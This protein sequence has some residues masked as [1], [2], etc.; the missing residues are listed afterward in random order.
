MKPPSP[1]GVIRVDKPAGP[2]SHD[3]VARARRALGVRRIGHTGTLDPFASGLLLLCVGPATRL[4]EYLTGLDK[5]YLATAVMGQSTDTDD[6]EGEVV[7]VSEAWRELDVAHISEALSEFVGLI[8]QVPPAFSAKKVGGERMYRRARRGETVR[9]DPASVQIHEARVLGVD[10]PE[11]RFELSCSSGTYVRAVARDLGE[12]VGT[13][14][15]LKALRRTRIGA[16]TVGDAVSGDELHDAAGMKA[17][18]LEPARAL[19]H[20]PKVRVGD[21]EAARI[22]HGQA[23]PLESDELPEGATLAVLHDDELLCIATSSGGRVRPRKVFG[24]G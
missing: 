24:D 16:F 23:V 9:L 22:R 6:L 17:A 12:R 14:A 13:G 20:L 10:L 4:A 18:W 21:E 1:G 11:V 19:P 5:T 2:T 3:I 7:R 8:E 15:H